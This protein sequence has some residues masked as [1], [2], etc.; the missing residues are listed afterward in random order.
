M[1]QINVGV[2]A[3][4]NTGDTIR[5][6]FQKVNANILE[7]A[8]LANPNFTGTVSGVT[9][10]MVG[11]GNADNTTDLLKP[12]STA[13]QTAL[14]LKANKADLDLTISTSNDSYFNGVRVGAFQGDSVILGKELFVFNTT[15]S[16]NV[17][18]GNKVMYNNQTGSDNTST[19]LNS[20]YG[21]FSGN[22]NS[23]YGSSSMYGN[24]SGNNNSAF[25]AGS[26]YNNQTGS[27][28]SAYGSGSMYG[29]TSGNNNTSVGYLSMTL[30][31]IYNNCSTLGFTAEVSGENQIQLG[32]ASTTTYVF[33]TVQNRSDLRDKADV[34]DTVLG[35]DFISKL[36]PVDYRW[37][38]RES[39]KSELPIQGELSDE[40]FKVEMN[41]W[42]IDNKLSNLKQNGT[43]KRN[44]FH[45][46]FIAQ[47]IR[48]LGIDFGGFQDHSKNGG[49]DVLSI[50]YDEFIAPMIKAIQE[51]KA[52]I[53]ILK[54]K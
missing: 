44:R 48:D 35:L 39:Y 52:E 17:A 46:G 42:L 20:M 25:G 10:A 1:V 28:N 12:I 36:R 40:D 4:D 23:A 9:K 29:N 31:T 41:A 34:Q 38:M 7:T 3:N 13:T 11:L 30:N 54:A 49:E 26:M 8:P 50:G 16:H 14:N 27:F 18:L 33:G 43:K 47:E 15:G 45:H 2:T 37:D 22:V 24:T 53:E 6:A 32:N 19:G 21:N 5:A 51:L